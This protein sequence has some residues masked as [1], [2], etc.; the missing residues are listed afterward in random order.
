MDY[1]NSWRESLKQAIGRSMGSD[2]D[3]P[4]GFEVQ[5]TVDGNQLSS[6]LNLP[7]LYAKDITDEDPLSPTFGLRYFVLGVDSLGDSTHPLSP[8]V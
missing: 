7:T 2:V 5:N 8:G 3:R 6:I 4:R 1:M